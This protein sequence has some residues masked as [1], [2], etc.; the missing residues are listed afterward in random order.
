MR[1]SL[2][3][4]P[5]AAS[6][7]KSVAAYGIAIVM[8]EYLS[9]MNLKRSRISPIAS[10]FPTHRVNIE[11]PI[12]TTYGTKWTNA[13]TLNRWSLKKFFMYSI[14]LILI[15]RSA[16]SCS[17][18]AKMFNTPCANPW[19][20]STFSWTASKSESRTSSWIARFFTIKLFTYCN[21]ASIIEIM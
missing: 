9:T 21:S 7:C 2:T 18:E 5:Y 20:P 1:K 3:V 12:F 4:Y 17:S 6:G 14:Q 19:I 16:L 10:E 13:F 15:H 11:L 8:Q